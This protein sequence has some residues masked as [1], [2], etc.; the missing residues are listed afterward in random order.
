MP[1]V[2]VSTLMK[3]DPDRIYATVRDMESYPK[4]MKDVVSVRITDSGEGWTVT[5]WLTSIDGRKIKWTER[6]EFNDGERVIQYRLLSGDL[7]K[8]EG[9]WRIE[10]EGETVRVTLTVDFEFGVPMLAPLLH[11][12]LKKKVKENS[13]AML[14]AIRGQIEN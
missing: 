14:E 5:D 6:D 11:P 9:F 4:F 12:I 7:K 1:Y 3:G 2:E 10:P 8:F 13:E